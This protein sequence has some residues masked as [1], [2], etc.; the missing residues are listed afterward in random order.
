MAKNKFGSYPLPAW[1][2]SY[3]E[4]NIGRRPIWNFPHIPDSPEG[5]SFEMLDFENRHHILEM[6]GN[7]P[8]PWVDERFKDPQQLYEYVAHL[9]IVMPYTGKRGGADWLVSKE[10]EYVGLLHAFEFSRENFGYNHRKC[11]MGFAFAENHRGAGLPLRAV[12]YFQ[13]FLFRKMDRL[14]LTASVKRGN[15]RSIAFLKKLGFRE[16]RLD[17]EAEHPGKEP[18]EEVYLENFRSPQARGRVRNY[19]KRMEEKYRT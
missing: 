12:Q 7:D 6:F 14:Y 16:T 1:L 5:L 19:W 9:R 2:Q 8:D 4:R 18:P 10:R 15:L 17:W 13:E 3:M 11:A